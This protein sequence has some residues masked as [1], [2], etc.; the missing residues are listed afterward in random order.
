MSR[1]AEGIPTFGAW[2]KQRRL[3]LNLTQAALA[4]SIGC[5]VAT[6]QKIEQGARTPSEQIAGL[7]ARALNISEADI[8]AVVAA[9]RSGVAPVLRTPTPA[10]ARVDDLIGRDGQLAALA[11]LLL[12]GEHRVVTLIGPGGVGKTALALALAHALGA[13]F[14]SGARVVSLA[15]ARTPELVPGVAISALTPEAGSGALPALLNALRAQTA[16]RL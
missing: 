12:R 15:D 10:L 11:E 5:A 1:D 3:T 6:L 7:L 4:R 13:H 8:P 16:D 9:A 14:E 2:A